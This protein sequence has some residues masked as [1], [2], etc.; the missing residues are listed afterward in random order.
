ME[1]GEFLSHSAPSVFAL[2]PDGR[3]LALADQEGFDELIR[4][5]AVEGG[6]EKWSLRRPPLHPAAV[7]ISPDDRRLAIVG[8][9]GG[10]LIWEMGSD[11]PIKLL[12]EPS[13]ETAAASSPVPLLVFAPDSRRLA[14]SGVD[15]REPADHVLT[16]FDAATGTPQLTIRGASAALAFSRDGRRLIA[17]DPEKG[18]A[19]TRV[20]DTAVGLERARLRGHSRPVHAAAFSPDGA[21]IVTSSRDGTLTVWDAAGRELLTLAGNGRALNQLRFN[22][23]GTRLIG[24]D[25]AGNVLT[26]QADAAGFSP[27][28]HPFLANP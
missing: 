23:D 19:E 9:G 26:W 28:H 5:L 1:Q 21:R 14:L 18:A 7:A 10:A 22:D 24:A 8:Q 2:S 11:R 25:D 4:V 27:V 13:N 12:D 16:L 6:Q 3:L 20:F 17:H 15:G